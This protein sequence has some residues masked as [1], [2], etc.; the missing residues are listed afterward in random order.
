MTEAAPETW[1][2]LLHR[3]EESTLYEAAAMA[4]SATSLGISVTIVW[5]DAALDALVSGGLGEEGDES[6]AAALLSSAR[7]TGLLTSLACSASAVNRAGG[8]AAAR[9]A[10]DD[11]VGWPT[12]IPLIRR[13]S[14][15]FVW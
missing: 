11:I 14:R 8:V 1:L 5:F 4:A 3:A 13:A 2:V 15:S 7:A 10:V 12:V 6:S 9:R